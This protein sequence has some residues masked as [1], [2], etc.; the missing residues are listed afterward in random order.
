[1]SDKLHFDISAAVVRQL[2]E[3][4][5]SDE[6]TAIIE[7]VKNSYDADASYANVIVDNHNFLDEKDLFYG[8]G[9]NVKPGYI[10]IEDNGTGM[11]YDE[12]KNGWLTIS[13]SHKRE[14]NKRGEVSPKKGRSQL[15]EKGLGAL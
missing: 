2:G 5:V 11:T 4:L 12:I 8:P 13:Y 14:M 3:E 1:M 9:N 15:G 10:I 7:L 6:V